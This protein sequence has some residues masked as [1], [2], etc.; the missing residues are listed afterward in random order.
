[1][2]LLRK[3]NFDDLVDNIYQTH[4]AL[5]DN[6]ARTINYSLTIRNWLVGHYI[7]EFE[8]NSTK[9]QTL[10]G[11]SMDIDVTS[12]PSVASR[13]S[14]SLTGFFVDN[15]K[16]PSTAPDSAKSQTLF[17]F[18]EPDKK[19]LENFIRKELAQHSDG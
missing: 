14:Q 10:S 4:C 15:K 8:Q 5:Q 18:L 17:G 6:A 13:K 2:P 16:R 3:N 19:L 1:M 12:T 7:V 11:F 9:S